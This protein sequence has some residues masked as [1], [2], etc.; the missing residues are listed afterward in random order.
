MMLSGPQSSLS[1]PRSLVG[2]RASHE[3]QVYLLRDLDPGSGLLLSTGFFDKLH[4]GPAFL[5]SADWHFLEM[6]DEESNLR[7]EI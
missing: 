2:C 6:K 7:E 4:L 1:Y 5:G 3:P